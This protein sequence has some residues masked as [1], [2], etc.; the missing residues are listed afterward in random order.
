MLHATDRRTQSQ[1]PLRTW[2]SSAFTNPLRSETTPE[3]R[4]GP[5]TLLSLGLLSGSLSPLVMREGFLFGGQDNT[6]FPSTVLHF[7]CSD[8]QLLKG[9]R[10]FPGLSTFMGLEPMAVPNGWEWNAALRRA[11]FGAMRGMGSPGTWVSHRKTCSPLE[12][13]VQGPNTWRQLRL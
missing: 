5:Q 7:L 9:Y 6:F 8:H 1:K 13:C 10:S 12:P 4:R 2:E 11:F 3:V